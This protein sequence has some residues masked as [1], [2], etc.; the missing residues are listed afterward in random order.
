[1]QKISL[2]NYA[3]KRVST[4]VLTKDDSTFHLDCV[5]CV[6]CMGVC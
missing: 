6:H 3:E 5:V 2:R 4:D 1:M